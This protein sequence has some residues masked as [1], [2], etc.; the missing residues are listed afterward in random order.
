MYVEY[1]TWIEGPSG[2]TLMI[3]MTKV[4]RSIMQ[5]GCNQTPIWNQESNEKWKRTHDKELKGNQEKF[6]TQPFCESLDMDVE[7]LQ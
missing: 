7:D 4:R 2:K 3:I 1:L 6:L 5:Q